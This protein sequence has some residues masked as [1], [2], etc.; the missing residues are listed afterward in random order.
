MGKRYQGTLYVNM[1][2]NYNN[3]CLILKR[4]NRDTDSRKRSRS[5]I[6]IIE[7]HFVDQKFD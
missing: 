6:K 3:Y 7:K 4:E 5:S 2:A 1:M